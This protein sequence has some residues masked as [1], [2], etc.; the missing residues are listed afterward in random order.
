MSDGVFSN[1]QNQSLI[2]KI[3]ATKQ[4]LA[5]KQDYLFYEMFA[6]YTKKSVERENKN[7]T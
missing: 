5:N 6:A 1:R 3:K 2:E 7:K 4:G